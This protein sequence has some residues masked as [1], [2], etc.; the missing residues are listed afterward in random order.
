[1]PFAPWCH[2]C[3]VPGGGWREGKGRSQPANCCVFLL[4]EE[5][6]DFA[7]FVSPLS[8]KS[9]SSKD[10]PYNAWSLAHS[11]NGFSV[12]VARGTCPASLN[13]DSPSFQPWFPYS[14]AFSMASSQL[15]PQMGLQS[16]H[17][18]GLCSCLPHLASF[19]EVNPNLL[20]LQGLREK[21]SSFLEAFPDQLLSTPKPRGLLL[22]PFGPVEH[23][24]EESC[25]LTRSVPPIFSALF[26]KVI[27]GLLCQ[28]KQLT[29]RVAEKFQNPN[30]LI[31]SRTAEP[32]PTPT[33]AFPYG[34]FTCTC[35][36]HWS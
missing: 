34:T 6:A 27:M 23:A 14:P 1:M 18:Q 12:N 2:V 11:Q 9:M 4:F 25:T 19:L 5:R 3:T 32:S 8:L 30:L 31:P 24:R 10:E 17:P 20:I 21:V 35:L 26:Q 33:P 22:I 28:R 15:V 29:F 36:L 7:T 16:F 13:V